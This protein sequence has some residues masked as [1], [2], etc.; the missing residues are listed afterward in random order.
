MRSSCASARTSDLSTTWRSTT[1]ILP[2]R[3]LRNFSASCLSTLPPAIC[4]PRS[5]PSE[6]AYRRCSQGGLR[7]QIKKL[8]QELAGPFL[9]RVKANPVE[10]I[11]T[12]LED[13]KAHRDKHVKAKH[14]QE[15]QWKELCEKNF[16]KSLDHRAFY[17]KQA[18]KKY[19]STKSFYNEIKERY[20]KWNLATTPEFIKKGGTLGSIYYNSL[21]MLPPEHF[22]TMAIAGDGIAA[23]SSDEVIR[24]GPKL[25][26]LHLRFDNG[27]AFKEAYRFIVEQIVA[28]SNTQAEK[29]K[30]RGIVDKIMQ[31]FFKFD[32]RK[33]AL[34]KSEF[35]TENDMKLFMSENFLQQRLELTNMNFN[36][37]WEA[38]KSRNM[39][40]SQSNDGHESKKP[41]V[42][43]PPKGTRG[44]HNKK[45][46]KKDTVARALGISDRGL[47][48]LGYTGPPMEFFMEDNIPKEE[49][50][51]LP[52]PSE[53]NAVMYGSVNFYSFFRHF[54]CLYERIIKARALAGKGLE[55]ELERRPELLAIYRALTEEKKL[56]LQVERYEE[57]YVKGL[58]SL[59]YGAIDIAKYEDFC[60]HCL[61]S[62]GYLMFSIDKLINSVCRWRDW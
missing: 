23:L 43:R 41:K 14:E 35:F 15:R 57:I 2:L 6:Y 1:A 12:F 59:L 40:D 34:S 19:I 52:V 37:A 56:L 18:E 29:E 9:E 22:H 28:G 5:N 49:R 60:R 8:F 4:T 13:I 39:Q 50:Q 42:N 48:H 27:Q 31:E 11:K 16:A 25:P 45:V 51:F 53:L 54:H 7:C 62:Q 38:M 32:T 17:F 30:A 10:I 24:L 20:D 47:T 58:K 3:A 46:D 36:D 44:G 61:G 33:V 55:E 21:T 26:Q